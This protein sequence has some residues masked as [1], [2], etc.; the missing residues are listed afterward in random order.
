[1]LPGAEPGV[2]CSLR[3]DHHVFQC[4]QG[5]NG[6]SRHILGEAH[7]VIPLVDRAGTDQAAQHPMPGHLDLPPVVVVDGLHPDR[8]LWARLRVRVDVRLQGPGTFLW[9]NPDVRLTLH[10]WP[11]RPSR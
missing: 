8:A 3:L 9:C 2:R 1:M 7:S 11:L 6:I 10:P 4:R 5:P